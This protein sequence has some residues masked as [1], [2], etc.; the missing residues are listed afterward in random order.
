[1][2]A[3]TMTVAVLAIFVS[4]FAVSP[5]I[6]HHFLSAQIDISF[7]ADTGATDDGV[8]QSAPD[9]KCHIGHSCMHAVL[10][11]NDLV[12][13]RFDRAPEFSS[14]ADYPPSV[15]RDMPFHPPR[16]LSRV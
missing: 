16:T 6:D 13:T 12:L 14:I 1:M 5:G 2:R 11:T 8:T 10:P 15:A 3:V 7:G 9:T 4:A